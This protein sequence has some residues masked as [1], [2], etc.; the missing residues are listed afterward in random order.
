MKRAA[1][2][3]GACLLGKDAAELTYAEAE[4]LFSAVCL[5]VGS[6]VR[7]LAALGIHPVDQHGETAIDL[8]DECT[9]RWGQTGYALLRLI[10]SDPEPVTK[11]LP[12]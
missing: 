3:A 9:E 1:A 2:C 8:F 11:D 5:A 7:R 12:H 6:A 4:E 10:D